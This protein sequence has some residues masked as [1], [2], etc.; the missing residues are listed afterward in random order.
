VLWDEFNVLDTAGNLRPNE[1]SWSPPAD[2]DIPQGVARPLP[3]IHKERLSQV[4]FAGMHADVGG[5]YPQAGLSYVTL[6]WMM[7][8]AVVYRLLLK[9]Q[10]A[11]PLR[12]CA[13]EYDKLNDWRHGLGGYYRVQPRKV[14]PLLA[15]VPR[16]ADVLRDIRYLGRWLKNPFAKDPQSD[17]D[18]GL[19][20]QS[21]SSPKIHES[22]FPTHRR[23]D[24][25]LQLNCDSS[26]V[27]GDNE[28][29]TDIAWPVRVGQSGGSARAPSGARVELGLGPP[30]CLLRHA[31]G[32]AHIGGD[33]ATA[34]EMTW[35]RRS[36]SGGFLD[37]RDRCGRPLPAF[38]CVILDRCFRQA[39]T[40]LL[41]GSGALAALFVG[42]RLQRQ[43]HDKLRPMWRANVGVPPHPRDVAPCPP[44]SDP[45]YLIRSSMVY[46]G[47]FYTLTHWV[48]P[49]V[50]F[51]AIV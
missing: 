23:R 3:A 19:D 41:L 43:I 20:A 46:R 26:G 18:N 40:W 37:P 8:R 35:K 32:I 21:F 1:E 24:R 29:R 36:Q 33:T 17:A 31:R 27:S 30:R 39:P 22:V 48:L 50:C 10:E 44:P 7:D 11:A 45:L 15:A 4:W 34:L 6:V 25:R 42:V 51:V 49:G 13:D 47:F 5:G 12:R 38:I 14:V 28:R 2:A 9:Q 16:K